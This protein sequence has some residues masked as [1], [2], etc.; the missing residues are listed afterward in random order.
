MKLASTAAIVMLVSATALAHCL[1]E[2]LQ[3]SLISI[4]KNRV[5]IEMTL[6]PGVS[7]FPAV[8][9]E[10]D[11]NADGLISADERRSYAGRVL[12]DITISIDG[13]SLM[14]RLVSIEFAPIAEMKEGRGEIRIE[15]EADLPAGGAK[16]K[17]TFENHHQSG[18]AA[19]QVNSLIPRDPQIQIVGQ[20]RN[21]SQ[22]F[23]EVEFVESG[24]HSNTQLRS[25]AGVAKPAGAIAL[26][27]VAG[28]VLLWRQ[29]DR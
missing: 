8:I 2:Y 24:I 11:A 7:V 26:L 21:Y 22:S 13:R 10:I 4:E 25:L 6:T 15:I 23:Y 28:A 20:N 17:L 14:P 1:D 19:Y 12:R 9:A 18:I 27:L 16:R 3:G 5:E 29:R